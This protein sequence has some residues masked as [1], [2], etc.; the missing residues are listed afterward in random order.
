MKWH[1]E[2]NWLDNASLL[3]QKKEYHVDYLIVQAYSLLLSHIQ[4]FAWLKS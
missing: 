3:E 1:Q 2:K 4:I